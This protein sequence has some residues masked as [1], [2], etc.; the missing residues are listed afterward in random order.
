VRGRNIECALRAVK[1]TF[2]LIV[3]S[4]PES[5][6]SGNGVIARVDARAE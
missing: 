4:S 5:R 2:E 3:L 1:R 6:F